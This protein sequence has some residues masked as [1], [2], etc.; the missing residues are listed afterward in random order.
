LESRGQGKTC[1]GSIPITSV[2]H[3]CYINDYIGVA[4]I[5]YAA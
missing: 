1:I 4:I 2:L 5:I 3:L